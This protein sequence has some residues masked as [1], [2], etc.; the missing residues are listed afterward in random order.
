MLT[1]N[2]SYTSVKLSIFPVIFF[3]TINLSKVFVVSNI[4]ALYSSEVLRILASKNENF[5][6]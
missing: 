5:M 1:S 2:I 4:L 6:K 3:S